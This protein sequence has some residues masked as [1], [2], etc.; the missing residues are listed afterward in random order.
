MT[1]EEFIQKWNV[2]FE[3]KEQ[4]AEFAEEMRSDLNKITAD[5][6][7]A[8]LM[9]DKEA[10]EDY[11]TAQNIIADLRRQLSDCKAKARIGVNQNH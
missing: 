3:S 6:K 2:A 8:I 10:K 4:E 9:R 5:L 11:T 1:K 7:Q